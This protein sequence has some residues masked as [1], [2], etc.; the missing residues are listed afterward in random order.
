MSEPTA[1]ARDLVAAILAAL[2]AH[3]GTLDLQIGAGQMID[4]ATDEEAAAL[5]APWL[6]LH[7]VPQELDTTVRR[8]P[9]RVPVIYAGQIQCCLSTKTADFAT[10]LAEFASNVMTLVGAWAAPGQRVRQG[11]LQI[12]N[13]WGLG[14]AVEPARRIA[15]YPGA[16]NSLPHGHDALV[17]S[18][19]QTLYRPERL[20]A[21]DPLP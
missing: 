2:R 3:F 1:T 6:M 18:W 10:E 15:C 8:Q 16:L 11:E 19:E 5:V 17:V 13:R 7:V 4:V 9:G 20:T 14:A 21:D 12:G